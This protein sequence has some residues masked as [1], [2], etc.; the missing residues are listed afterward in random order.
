MK[1]EGARFHM[2]HKLLVELINEYNIEF[3]KLPSNMN[4]INKTRQ[5]IQ[6][7]NN[8]NNTFKT[9]MTNI[10]DKSKRES[11]TK[12][13]SMTTKQYIDSLCGTNE[14][15]TKL[16]NIF[17]YSSEFLVMN[18][19]DALKQFEDDF[20]TQDFYVLKKGFTYFI[21]KLVSN[22][23]NMGIIF[24]HPSFAT[25]VMK[26]EKTYCVYS[27]NLSNN[28]IQKFNTHNVVFAT[29]SEQLK[30]FNILNTIHKHLSCI[31]GQPLLRI[32]A[33]FPK[34]KQFGNKPWF[35][36]LNRTTT[37]SFLRHIIPIDPTS[38]LIMISY[39]DG[40]DVSPFLKI[41]IL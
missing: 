24:N 17:G 23:Q 8:S 1:L 14:L 5:D 22:L 34:L 10:I 9:I 25:N 41:K 37:N 3:Q 13:L 36:D 15:S 38:G 40:K 28:K 39:T 33:K 2:K 19:Y 11:K 20:I 30:Q 21:S 26:E 16:I 7:Y 18:A 27:K 12:L 4:Y 6:Y 29:K 31:S 35:H 32:Y